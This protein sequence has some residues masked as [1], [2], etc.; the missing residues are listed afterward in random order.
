ME[1]EEA[2]EVS[3]QVLTEIPP[4]SS[5]EHLRVSV[6]FSRVAPRDAAYL[7]A[8]CCVWSEDGCGALPRGAVPQGHRCSVGGCGARDLDWCRNAGV[9][10][11]NG[12]GDH[13]GKK[14]FLFRNYREPGFFIIIIIIIIIIEKRKP[15]TGRGAFSALIFQVL[16]LAL[17]VILGILRFREFR[18][19]GSTVFWEKGKIS[20]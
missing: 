6:S 11:R 17:A 2:L 19:F 4:V 8:G 3:L 9:G 15:S 10:T 5:C 12:G 18:E 13:P 20:G 7:A 1:N 14:S 16:L